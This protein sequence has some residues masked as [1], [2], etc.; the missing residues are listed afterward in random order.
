MTKWKLGW[1]AGMLAIFSV[2]LPTVAQSSVTPSYRFM[3]STQPVSGRRLYTLHWVDPTNP[4]MP[5]KR[6]TLDDYLNPCHE[7]SP[8]GRW[9][10]LCYYDP[11]GNGIVY[12]RGLMLLDL[13]DTSIHS[14]ASIMVDGDDISHLNEPAWSPDSRYFVFADYTFYGYNSYVY[15]V[16][17]AA[18][19][20]ITVPYFTDDP[21]IWGDRP[22]FRLW[23][24]DSQ[25]ILTSRCLDAQCINTQLEVLRVGDMRVVVSKTFETDGFE[26]CDF[27]WSPDNRYIS[28][29]TYCLSGGLPPPFREIFIWD[30]KLDAFEQLT[31]FTNPPPE[32]WAEYPP[33]RHANY[34]TLWYDAQTLLLGAQAYTII[35]GVGADNE[36]FVT[37]SLLYQ[38]P[39]AASVTLNDTYA[40]EWSLNPVTGD[41][42]FLSQTLTVKTYDSGEQSM[43]VTQASVQAASVENGNLQTFISAPAGYDLRWSPDGEMLGYT[44]TNNPDYYREP[45]DLYFL[46][47][48]SRK[49]EHFTLPSRDSVYVEVLGWGLAPE[50]GQSN[51]PYFVD[52]TPTPIPMFSGAG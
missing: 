39:S 31:H 10:P 28:L 6:L 30:T 9:L 43:E 50:N 20:L 12:T 3:Y 48:G 36:N 35:Y 42:A 37:Q 19:T 21:D 46:H 13:V 16:K 33:E 34:S 29:M 4:D 5:E 24:A 22:I 18:G 2:I 15:D 23:S 32:E 17:K 47:M 38:F 25:H 51:V 7:T 27:N 26:L 44:S 52:G 14:I 41:I 11:S 49:V 45:N 8:D 1:F 40:R